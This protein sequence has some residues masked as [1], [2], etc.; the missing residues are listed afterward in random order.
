MR[1]R[2]AGA[3]V[4]LA[5]V[6][7]LQSGCALSGHTEAV[8]P[9]M[10]YRYR[11][12]REVGMKLSDSSYIRL[13]APALIGDSIYGRQIRPRLVAGQDSMRYVRIDD[14]DSWTWYTRDTLSGPAVGFIGITA[15]VAVVAA[16]VTFF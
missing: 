9:G 12:A 14:V 3:V 11:M 8:E 5:T 15:L 13:A 7:V 6:T 4:L 2:R 1:P 16:L 10:A